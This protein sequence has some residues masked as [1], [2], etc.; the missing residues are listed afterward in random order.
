MIAV[1]LQRL[2]NTTTCLGFNFLSIEQ[3]MLEGTTGKNNL[4][5]TYSVSILLLSEWKHWLSDL[6]KAAAS[7]LGLSYEMLGSAIFL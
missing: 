1:S 7:W 5:L 3:S 4:V 6:Q 2:M